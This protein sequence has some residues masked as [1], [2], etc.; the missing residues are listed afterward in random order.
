MSAWPWRQ[1]PGVGAGTVVAE[2]V[3]RSCQGWEASTEG[4]PIGSWPGYILSLVLLL[5]LQPWADQVAACLVGVLQTLRQCLECRILIRKYLWDQCLWERGKEA[6]L[7]GD[8]QPVGPLQSWLPPQG[9]LELEWPIGVIPHGAQK[10][11]TLYP[12]LHSVIGWEGVWPWGS[13]LRL[14]PPPDSLAVE[15]SLLTTSRATTATSPPLKGSGQRVSITLGGC[16]GLP[17]SS[18]GVLPAS[19]EYRARI[20]RQGSTPI[21]PLTE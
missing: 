19:F 18:Q 16:G 9:A 4:C 13:S 8:K 12:L 7:A 17:H 11:G 10:A 21:L 15:N 6:R 20:R 3:S 14:R 5:S 1:K 2:S